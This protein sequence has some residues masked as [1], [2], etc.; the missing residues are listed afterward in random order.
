MLWLFALALVAPAAVTADDFEVKLWKEWGCLTHDFTLLATGHGNWGECV[1]LVNPNIPELC[2]NIHQDS[3]EAKD[4]YS[5]KVVQSVADNLGTVP[6][7]KGKNELAVSLYFG[8]VNGGPCNENDKFPTRPE[9]ASEQLGMMCSP[10]CQDFNYWGKPH[11]IQVHCGES[12][13]NDPCFASN[14]TAC[15]INTASI[16]PAEAFEACYGLHDGDSHTFAAELV[17]M[18]NLIAGDQVL[19]SASTM[20]RVL[21]NQHVTLEGKKSVLLDITY[22]GGMLSITPDH[23][24]MLDGKYAPASAATVGSTML[25]AHMKPIEVISVS[26]S[27]GSIVNPVT[28]MGTILAAGPGAATPIISSV[29]GEWIASPMLQAGLASQPTLSSLAAYLF[30]ATTQT[31]HDALIE[32]FHRRLRQKLAALISAIPGCMYKPTLLLLDIASA[33]AFC[34]YATVVACLHITGSIAVL[35]AATKMATSW[36]TKM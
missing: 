35:L 12:S 7:E 1:T 30:P 27:H 10:S 31:F 34:F 21:F 17:P 33:S 29:Y 20:D 5:A 22:N 15:R 24:L 18:R 8:D 19:A 14:T 9:T 6:S 32:P 3:Q 25:N 28:S 16:T 2:R 4:C 11:S 36:R 26:T 23:M 13:D